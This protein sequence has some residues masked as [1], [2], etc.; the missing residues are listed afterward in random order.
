MTP[1]SNV[2]GVGFPQK[3][4]TIGWDGCWSSMTSLMSSSFVGSTCNS[5]GMSWSR[6]PKGPGAWSSPG[7]GNRT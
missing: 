4:D 7:S 2:G 1:S 5:V 6:P 3:E